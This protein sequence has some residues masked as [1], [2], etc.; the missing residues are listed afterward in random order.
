M[1]L[2]DHPHS[3]A[4]KVFGHEIYSKSN[5]VCYF[6]CLARAS[7]MAIAIVPTS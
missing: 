3:G 6:F 2:G 5:R 4:L 7:A 1:G